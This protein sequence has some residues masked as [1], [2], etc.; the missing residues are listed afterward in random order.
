MQLQSV[1]KGGVCIIMAVNNSSKTIIKFKRQLAT[2]LINSERIV[3]LIHNQEID[4]PEDLMYNNIFN[5]IRIP[6][7]PEEQKNYLCYRVYMPEV[8]TSNM[9][10]QKLV[11]EVYTVSHQNEMITD[12]GATRIDLLAEEVEALLDGNTSFGKK[13]LELISN[14][15]EGFGSHHRCRVLRFEAFDTDQCRN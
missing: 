12:E 14:E 9:F 3:E 13:P 8:Y 10:F 7:S 1:R 4:N 11:V 5:F 2:M 15:E 6:K